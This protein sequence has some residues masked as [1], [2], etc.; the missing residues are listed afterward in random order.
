MSQL[1]LEHVS[2]YLPY[3]VKLLRSYNKEIMLLYGLSGN[4]VIE[5]VDIEDNELCS[6]LVYKSDIGI[7]DDEKF[8]LILRPLSDLKEDVNYIGGRT[9]AFVYHLFEREGNINHLPFD[10]IIDLLKYHYDI[11]NLI[12][13]GLAI[14][15]DTLNK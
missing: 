12:Q 11:F 6:L 9:P 1:T 14:D 15:I 5:A 8:K 4:G 13:D 2:A 10:I 7:D 3:K